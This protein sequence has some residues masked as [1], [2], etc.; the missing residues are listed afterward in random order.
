[1]PG[2]RHWT[3][4]PSIQRAAM[5]GGRSRVWRE[6]DKLSHL[7]C[8]HARRGWISTAGRWCGIPGPT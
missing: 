2:A 3:L 5:I 6:L 1:M 8:G 7:A 4:L